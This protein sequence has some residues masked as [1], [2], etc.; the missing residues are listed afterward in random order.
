[1]NNLD[2]NLRKLEKIME[3]KIFSVG[4]EDC[5]LDF[6]NTRHQNRIRTLK[7]NEA[8][9]VGFRP[10]GV[11]ITFRLNDVK[12]YGSLGQEK[13]VEAEV[14]PDVKPMV[15][16]TAKKKPKIAVREVEERSFFTLKEDL[17]EFVGEPVIEP[18]I[19]PAI[20]PA[21][22]AKAQPEKSDKGKEKLAAPKSGRKN[23]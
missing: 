14:K 6:Y 8:V 12:V 21:K 11:R 9:V 3:D 15:K 7:G 1:M 18:V 4:G 22:R 20:K 19:K 10:D 5:S 2:E 13:E 16:P 17:D 23:K